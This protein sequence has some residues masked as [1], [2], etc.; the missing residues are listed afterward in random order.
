MADSPPGRVTVDRV[1]QV[2]ASVSGDPVALRRLVANLVDNALQHAHTCTIEIQHKEGSVILHVD[3]DGPGIPEAE[4]FAIFEPFY[5][6]EHSRSR[7]TGGSGLGLTIAKQ[8]VESHDGSIAIET[9]PQKGARVTI[10]PPGL[11]PTRAAPQASLRRRG[12]SEI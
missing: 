3:D 2:C 1:S 6:L 9:S 11:P 8:I 7:A 12:L 4:R 5:R 10:E